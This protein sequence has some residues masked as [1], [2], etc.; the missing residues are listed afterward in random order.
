MEGG[1]QQRDQGAH[2]LRDFRQHQEA[3]GLVKPTDGLEKP[4]IVKEI[5]SALPTQ[6]SQLGRYISMCED[7]AKKRIGSAM[8]DETTPD[9]SCG[10]RP[11]SDTG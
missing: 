1:G 4:F 8:A 11:A 9:H 5:N 3:A 10:H 6:D 7:D 2:L